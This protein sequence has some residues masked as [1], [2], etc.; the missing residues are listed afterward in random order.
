MS[1][2]VSLEICCA[3]PTA[4]P[5][6]VPRDQPYTVPPSNRGKS[7]R[8]EHALRSGSGAT[9]T[10]A[11]PTRAGLNRCWKANI[12]TPCERADVSCALQV[13]VRVSL[14]EILTCIMAGAIDIPC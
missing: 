3:K 2:Y 10:V 1:T 9:H 12:P 5:Y 4:A 6:A 13:N 11:W 8:C 14:S 7:L